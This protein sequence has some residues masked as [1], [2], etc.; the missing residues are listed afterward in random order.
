MD[1]KRRLQLC[2]QIIISQFPLGLFVNSALLRILGCFTPF[3]HGLFVR[4]ATWLTH[5]H[6]AT[7]LAK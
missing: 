1:S 7:L 4:W 3:G 6:R 5:G 2:V